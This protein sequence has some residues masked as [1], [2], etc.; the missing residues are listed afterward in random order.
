LGLPVFQ[1]YGLSECSSVVALNRAGDNVAG[2][3]GKPLPHIQVSFDNGE[4]QVHGNS[5]LGYLEDRNS[6]YPKYVKTGDLIAADTQ[7]RL[8]FSGRRRNQ[9]ISSLGRNISPEWPEAELLSDGLLTQAVVLGDD[10]A[11]CIAIVAAAKPLAEMNWR[12]W[13]ARINAKLPDYAQVKQCLLL[14]R[15]MSS[16]HRLMTANGR[17]NREA[18]RQFFH[19][20]IEALYQSSETIMRAIT[21]EV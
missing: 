6:W 18:I 8:W 9:I 17:P 7:G 11:H 2:S 15:A 13:L 19:R 5:F 16:Q 4:L 3:I 21:L 10:K 12:S 1:G 14:D 20:E